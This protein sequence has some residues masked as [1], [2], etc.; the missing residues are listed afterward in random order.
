[1]VECP[2]PVSPCRV[3]LGLPVYNGE[4]YLRDTLE[5]MV[6]QTFPDFE[7]VI[8][9]NASTD[10]TEAICREFADRDPRIHYYRQE[11]NAGAAA[12]FNRVFHLCHARYFKWVTHDDLCAP[13]YLERCVR[14]L[15]QDS[16]VVLCYAIHNVIDAAGKEIDRVAEVLP[17][18]EPDAS[19]RYA[20]LLR[21]FRHNTIPCDPSLG[22]MRADVLRQTRL[23]GPYPV[24][25]F[26]LLAE[27]SL[28]GRFLEIK[29]YL[30]TRRRHPQMS[31]W[32]YPTLAERAVWFDPA[33]AGRIQFPRWRWLI[34]LVRS[35]DRVGLSGMER[36]RCYASTALW[37]WYWKRGLVGDVAR[38]AQQLVRRCIPQRPAA[39][40][41]GP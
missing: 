40:L 34:E 18:D 1:M 23:L 8:S 28:R 5:S 37:C 15:E 13:T 3:S 16:S 12:N 32:A 26:T 19:R 21:R 29:E 24:S 20:H 30:F 17:V 39:G 22:L 25:D 33:N 31:T 36:L 2:H 14:H 11:Q 41:P 9:D 10:G 7:L 27:L 38:G 4:L 6:A 35:I